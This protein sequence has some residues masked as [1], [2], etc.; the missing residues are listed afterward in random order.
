HPNSPFAEQAIELGMI[1][2][3]MSTGGPNYDGRKLAEAR[4]MIDMALRS[5]PDLAN[6]KADFINRQ[7]YSITMQQ[8]TK[9]YDIAEFYR[10]TGHPCSAWFCYE[11]VRRRYPGTK[12]YDL[13]GERMQALRGKLD[14]SSGEEVPDPTA[15]YENRPM[16]DSHLAPGPTD[17]LPQPKPVPPEM[18]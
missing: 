15:K 8:A 13:A 18:L 5:Y 4:K 9:D 17:V 16:P 12:Y 7:L 2:K 10:R 1:S 11:V 6:K 3:Q 14:K